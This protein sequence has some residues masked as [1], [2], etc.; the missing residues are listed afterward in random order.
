MHLTCYLYNLK[1]IFNINNLK[2]VFL[3]VYVKLYTFDINIYIIKFQFIRF[4]GLIGGLT[5]SIFI[6]IIIPVSILFFDSILTHLCHLLEVYHFF[7]L[8]PF[9]EKLLT[10]IYSFYSNYINYLKSLLEL[11][12]SLNFRNLFYFFQCN[13]LFDSELIANNS[14]F[15]EPKNNFS[16]MMENNNN[17]QL[18]NNNSNNMNNINN[19]NQSNFNP[20]NFHPALTD[21]QLFRKTQILGYENSC[22]FIIHND[23]LVTTQLSMIDYY[24][25][26]INSDQATLGEKLFAISAKMTINSL[27]QYKEE[28]IYDISLFDKYQ[29]EY[30]LPNGNSIEHDLHQKREDAVVTPNS[31]QVEIILNQI[32]FENEDG[33]FLDQ[34]EVEN[35]IEN[36]NVNQQNLIESHNEE[37]D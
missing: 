33:V 32:D 18:V 1:K 6:F 34:H 11:N 13:Y 26:V 37:E 20:N 17:N 3:S 21:Y 16:L 12:L 31:H 28:K 7:D 15:L 23:T 8:L 14:S 30:C 19:F 29:I 5:I 35:G 24:D 25:K 36:D 22:K 27:L 2:F 4:F 10:S 9:N